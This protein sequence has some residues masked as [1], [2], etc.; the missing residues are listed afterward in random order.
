VPKNALQSLFDTWTET[1]LICITADYCIK[2]VW[3]RRPR[4]GAA[5]RH[6]HRQV[7]GLL[8]RRRVSDDAE[9]QTQNH[10]SLRV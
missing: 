5:D 1:K 6:Q 3:Y 8:Q 7:A 2:A 10:H 4:R 9:M